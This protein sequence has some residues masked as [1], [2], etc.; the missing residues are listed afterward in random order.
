MPCTPAYAKLRLQMQIDVWEKPLL[1]QSIV[2]CQRLSVRPGRNI[3][4]LCLECV[5]PLFFFLLLF[6]SGVRMEDVKGAILYLSAYAL[7]ILV[8]IKPE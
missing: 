5:S 1:L 2:V 6:S 7:V 3:S 8:A 4:V